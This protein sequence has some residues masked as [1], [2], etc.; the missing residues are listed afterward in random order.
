MKKFSKNDSLEPPVRGATEAAQQFLLP[1]QPKLSQQRR[2][3]KSRAEHFA[4]VE[5]HARFFTQLVG[6]QLVDERVRRLRWR[7]GCRSA[8]K[9]CGAADSVCAT[10]RNHR[11]ERQRRGSEAAAKSEA[12]LRS[13]RPLAVRRG[14]EY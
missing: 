3:E 5:P 13:T 2:V 12:R 4:T 1:L 7:T 9:C 8:A 11:A 14:N 10:G 6:N